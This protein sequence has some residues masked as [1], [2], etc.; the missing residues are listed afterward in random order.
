MCTLKYKSKEAIWSTSCHCVRW[1]NCL[2][3]QKSFPLYLRREEYVTV[4]AVC[5]TTFCLHTALAFNTRITCDIISTEDK[6]YLNL[7]D[8]WELWWIRRRKKKD[9]ATTTAVEKKLLTKVCPTLC[10]WSGRLLKVDFHNLL[11]LRQK[12]GRKSQNKHPAAKKKKIKTQIRVGGDRFCCE[13]FFLRR[14]KKHPGAFP[15]PA[16]Q[17]A[18]AQGSFVLIT[19][20]TT[21]GT[22]F[23]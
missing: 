22:D 3:F 21:C 16:T 12:M 5:I 8:A 10:Q 6:R 15:L 11:K 7:K 18:E 19:H 23:L 2:L 1:C 20:F 17:D 9:Y 4:T 13:P 14:F